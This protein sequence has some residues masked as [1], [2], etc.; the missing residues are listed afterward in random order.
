V[1]YITKLSLL[2]FR[3]RCFVRRR[4]RSARSSNRLAVPSASS[5][6]PPWRW[7]EL[8]ELRGDCSPCSPNRVKHNHKCHI[9][10]GFFCFNDVKSVCICL[11]V[12]VGFFSSLYAAAPLYGLTFTTT[13]IITAPPPFL[14]HLI[15]LPLAAWGAASQTVLG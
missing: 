15:F 3:W 5:R 14:L 11:C 10:R 4:E 13:S 12:C 7:K 6:M 8:P 9:E 2:F 1:F